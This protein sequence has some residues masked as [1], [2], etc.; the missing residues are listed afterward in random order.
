MPYDDKERTVYVS[1]NTRPGDSMAWGDWRDDPGLQTW[2]DG[3]RDRFPTSYR[4]KGIPMT[5]IPYASGSDYSGNLCER[6]NADVLKERFPWLVTLYGGYGTFGVAFLGKRENQNPELLEALN[7]LQGYPLVDEDHHSHLKMEVSDQAWE[8]YGRKDWT[9]A[10]V[11]LFDAMEYTCAW[12]NGAG[13]DECHDGIVSCTHDE[14]LIP[15]NLADRLYDD[16]AEALRGGERYLNESGDSIW[17]P[18]DRIVKQLRDPRYADTLA[19]PTWSGDNRPIAEKLDQ[20]REACV[21]AE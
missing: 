20:I 5:L 18:I 2:Y 4:A 11:K 7:D 10:L 12:C 21:V 16:C 13:C 3:P 17:F 1:P 19:K 8:S 14:D 9:R 15:N 6:S